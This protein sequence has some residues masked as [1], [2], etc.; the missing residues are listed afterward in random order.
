MN[1]GLLANRHEILIN[2]VDDEITTERTSKSGL[3]AIEQKLKMMS[4]ANEI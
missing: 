4:I 3:Q 1:A 2:D